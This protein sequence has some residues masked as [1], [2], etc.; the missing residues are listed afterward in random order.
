MNKNENKN[1]LHI[2]FENPDSK[3]LRNRI[4]YPFLSKNSSD[5]S[6]NKYI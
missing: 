4:R 2:F 1:Y 5:K 3:N 6:K